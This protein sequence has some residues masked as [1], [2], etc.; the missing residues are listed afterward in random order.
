[1]TAYD[2]VTKGVK[3]IWA[4]ATDTE[5]SDVDGMV[6]TPGQRYRF[7]TPFSMSCPWN[8]PHHR[9]PSRHRSALESARST[10]KVPDRSVSRSS[11][12]CPTASSTCRRTSRRVSYPASHA[13]PSVRVRRS[14]FPTS[15][16]ARDHKVG[17][18]RR[19]CPFGRGDFGPPSLGPS[20]RSSPR[21]SAT[22]L[23]RVAAP[24]RQPDCE[25]R[26]H[27][28]CDDVARDQRVLGQEKR[29]RVF[30]YSAVAALLER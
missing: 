4:I 25:Q 10:T 5:V 16:V 7:C 2:I 28:E 27:L 1:M 20:P 8:L 18:G 15:A 26:T 6:E 14:R 30:G 11:Y 19:C 23:C 29:Q 24:R 13:S 22:T 21:A 9:S 17:R 3:P 12:L